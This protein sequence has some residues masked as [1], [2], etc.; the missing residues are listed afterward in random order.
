MRITSSFSFYCR[1]SKK[2]RDSQSP[3]E[4]SIIINQKRVFLNLPMKFSPEDFNR[5]RKPPFV[6]AALNEW[7]V[8][9]TNVLTDM[10]SNDIPLTA[11]TLRYYLRTGGVKP[12]TIQDLFKEFL[13]LQSKRV[14]VEITQF[15]YRKYELTTELLSSQI[16]R[17]LPIANLTPS[18][19]REF[20]CYLQSRYDTTTSASYIAKAKT[21]V[22]YALDN[23]K[24]KINP[25]QGLKVTRKSK[26]IDYLNNEE[27]SVLQNARLSNASLQRVLDTFLFQIGSGLSYSDC[28]E[29]TPEDIQETD[30]TYYIKKNR[31]KTGVQFTSVLLPIAVAVLKKYD[32][33]LPKYCNQKV[34]TYLKSIGTLLNLNHNLTSHLGRKTYGHLLLNDY[35]VRMETVAKCLGHSNA[36]TTAKYYAEVSEETILKEVATAIH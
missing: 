1:E 9:I 13:S 30:G 22:Q 18:V 7:R 20:Y 24:L 10:L 29:L 35:G 26:R 25:F 3:L 6:V 4:L 15:S 32:Y 5:K 11:E 34:N 8:T 2:N 23:G 21:I 17:T 16:D 19:I 31:H 36:K 14:G 27:I 33:S 12:Y 28:Y